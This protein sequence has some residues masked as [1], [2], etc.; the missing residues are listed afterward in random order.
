MVG[1]VHIFQ[2]HEEVGGTRRG[3]QSISRRGRR[4]EP[5]RS[6]IVRPGTARAA[7]GQRGV[8]VNAADGAQ[9]PP[10]GPQRRRALLLDRT[11]PQHPL[12]VTARL[13]G[14]LFRQPGLTDAR[15][16][17]QHDEPAAAGQGLRTPPLQRG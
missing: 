12:P 8:C 10:P 11:F 1:P 17:G 14:Q 6:Q 16:T 3:R 9:D 4:T 15:R 7:A 2:H 5:G 13:V